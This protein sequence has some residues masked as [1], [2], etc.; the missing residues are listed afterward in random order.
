MQKENS[1]LLQLQLLSI[2][3]IMPCTNNMDENHKKILVC[4]G[5]VKHATILIGA[6][7]IFLDSWRSFLDEDHLMFDAAVVLDNNN[8]AKHYAQLRDR[9]N[10]WKY[11]K[12]YATFIHGLPVFLFYSLFG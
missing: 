10:D 3:I 2:P 5:L 9:W 7:N 12:F 6:R 11:S 1:L 8:A 4:S